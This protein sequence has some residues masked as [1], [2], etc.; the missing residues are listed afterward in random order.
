MIIYV[1][2]RLAIEAAGKSK[3]ITSA[4][5]KLSLNYYTTMSITAVLLEEELQIKGVMRSQN[6]FS[7]QGGTTDGTQKDIVAML[8]MSAFEFKSSVWS[9]DCLFVPSVAP[10]DLQLM[11]QLEYAR[12]SEYFSEKYTAARLALENYHWKTELARVFCWMCLPSFIA[13]VCV[14]AGLICFRLHV[15][16]EKKWLLGAS[17][18]Y[19]I[20]YK[21][22]FKQ[23]IKGLDEAT[24]SSY[25]KKYNHRFFGV[26]RE[27]NFFHKSGTV[28][29]HRHIIFS[30]LL[31]LSP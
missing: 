24:Y 1:V 20:L 26:W 18:F 22:G 17:N 16:W 25:L 2:T 19:D 13:G 7:D 6:P 12:H 4:L 23:A 15:R 28:T 11:R 10:E 30:I 31:F 27:E 21:D 9:M 14:L 29:S 8:K 5:V 3:A